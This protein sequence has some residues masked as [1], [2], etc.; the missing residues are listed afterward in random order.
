VDVSGVGMKEEGELRQNLGGRYVF[1]VDDGF[2]VVFHPAGRALPLV[3]FGVASILVVGFTLRLLL[4]EPEFNWLAWLIAALIDFTLV[5][6]FHI[7]RR[8][9]SKGPLIVDGAERKIL[10]HGGAEIAFDRLRALRVE[11]VGD[12]ASL[13]IEHEE[14][15]VNLAPRPVAEVEIAAAAVARIT[16]LAIDG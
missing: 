1:E 2:R 13:S 8:H 7:A 15:V 3:L 9:L 10:F 4:Q 11:R 6:A 5:L 14:G 12:R 16:E